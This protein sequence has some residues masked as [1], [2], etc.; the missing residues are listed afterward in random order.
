VPNLM[1]VNPSLSVKTVPE[2]IAYA[3][4]NPGKINMAS[5]AVGSGGH[6]AGE[7]FK[8]MTGI[9]FTHVPY[10]GNGPALTALLA[11]EV[12][13][14]FAT[15]SSSIEFVRTS[16]LRALAITSSARSEALPHVPTV[17]ESIPGYEVTSWHGI[18]AP[19]ATPAEIIDKLNRET[20]AGLAD[21]QL[22]AR[23]AEL[24]GIVMPG[25]AA[26]FGQFI[27]DETEKWRKVI[28]AA[29]LRAD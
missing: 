24:G 8:I 7:L 16:G 15:M 11:G 28:L 3:K 2:F 14:L 20:N 17:A 19:K 29:N 1:M 9:T 22:K 4:A 26:D 10:R 5:A 27:A 18:G 13:L 6:L 23:F 21:P 25:S 12:E